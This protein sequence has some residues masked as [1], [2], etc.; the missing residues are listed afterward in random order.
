MES[1]LHDRTMLGALKRRLLRR[2]PPGRSAWK[3][4]KYMRGSLVTVE[5]TPFFS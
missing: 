4:E 5:A 3:Q 1:G 2:Q